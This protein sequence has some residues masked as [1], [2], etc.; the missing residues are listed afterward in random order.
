MRRWFHGTS[1][2]E[3]LL[4]GC[5]E[6]MGVEV[7]AEEFLTPKPKRAGKKGPKRHTMF[8]KK[9]MKSKNMKKVGAKVPVIKIGGKSKAPTKFGKRKSKFL[10]KK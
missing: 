4:L 10:K 2:V 8:K 7:S 3:L 5:F 1:W 9:P 6:F